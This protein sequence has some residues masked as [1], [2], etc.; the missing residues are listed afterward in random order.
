MSPE[1]IS[2]RL[3]LVR[4]PPQRALPLRSATP[5]GAGPDRSPTPDRICDVCAGLLALTPYDPHTD[6]LHAQA[7]ALD[8][9]RPLTGADPLNPPSARAGAARGAPG[10]PAPAGAPPAPSCS[11]P[12]RTPPVGPC[13][14]PWRPPPTTPPAGSKRTAVPLGRPTPEST[15]QHY[16]A[17]AG[18]LADPVR[19]ASRS[20]SESPQPLWLRCR[21]RMST[22]VRDKRDNPGRLP[23][24]PLR[25]RP[26]GLRRGG[27]LVPA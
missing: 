14:P 15:R 11:T 3:R 13:W 1:P 24:R 25:A 5:P 27:P 4:S 18:S 20:L 26:A 16:E 22:A 2:R 7:D 8:A 9:V 12:P 23:P 19:M 10:R 6:G 17:P 21:Q